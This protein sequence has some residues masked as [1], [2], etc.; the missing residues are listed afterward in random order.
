[1]HLKNF[2]CLRL[3]DLILVLKELSQLQYASCQNRP[4]SQRNSFIQQTAKMEEKKSFVT[5]RATVNFYL[6]FFLT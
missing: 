5:T 2:H 6:Y 4:L 3:N 1:M